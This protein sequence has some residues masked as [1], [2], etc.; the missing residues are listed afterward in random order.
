MQLESL[1]SS[2]YVIPL[3]G[4]MN[5]WRDGRIQRNGEWVNKDNIQSSANMS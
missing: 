1:E 4:K 2:R 5:M 3:A